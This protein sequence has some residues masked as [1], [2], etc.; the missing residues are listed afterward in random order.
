MNKPGYINNL[1]K[2]NNA[3]FTFSDYATFVIAVSTV[4]YTIGTFLLWRTTQKSLSLTQMEIQNTR[5]RMEA[6]FVANTV[7]WHRELYT[8]ILSN[9]DFLKLL[10]TSENM[11]IQKIKEGFLGT[12]L[13]NNVMQAFYHNKS[14]MINSFLWGMIL[15]D[16][17]ELFKWRIVSDRWKEIESIVPADFKNFINSQILIDK[18]N[19]KA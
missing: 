16:T 1:I 17:E 5:K 2:M 4:I 6:G 7:A 19:R 8:F 9:E 10:A 14:N 12:L 13:I 18:D 3:N 11:E 15:K